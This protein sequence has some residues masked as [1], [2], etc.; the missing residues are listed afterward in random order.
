[1]GESILKVLEYDGT[2]YE[3][4]LESMAFDRLDWI[5]LYNP[6]ESELKTLSQTVGI[7]YR[8][9]KEVAD[10]KERPRTVELEHFKGVVFQNVK[11]AK[12]DIT[13]H[14][15]GFFLSEKLLISVHHGPSKSIEEL[16]KDEALVKYFSKGLMNLMIKIMESM[17]HR[18]F[19][20]LDEIETKI[21]DI[22]DTV[23]EDPSKNTVRQIFH[24]K[25]TLI[26]FHKALGANIEVIR[27]LEKNAPE[28]ML[29]KLR[30]LH[31]DIYQLNDTVATYRDI[32]TGALDIYLSSVSNNMN[33]VM[34][35]MTAWASLVLIPTFITGLYGMNFR[36]MPE[37]DWPYGYLF[38]WGLILGSVTFLA[39]YFKRKG[40]F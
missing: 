24:L 10:P 20:L 18:Y 25:K 31:N 6:T 7:S 11:Q 39:V 23:L 21:D 34:K 32:L 15:T 40:W 22:E 36:V 13:T 38:A 8:D 19:L 3:T 2:V 29:H 28:E 27:S 16:H 14:A 30:Y 1:M 9:L 5:D 4:T 12:D 35:R 17:T 26:Y 37:L 33:A